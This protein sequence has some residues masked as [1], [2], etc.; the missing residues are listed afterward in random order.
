MWLVPAP[1]R[2]LLLSS[3]ASRSSWLAITW[4]GGHVGGQYNRTFPR[5]IYM[6]IEFSSQK[7]KMHTTTHTT[8]SMRQGLIAGFAKMKDGV[9]EF[10]PNTSQTNCFEGFWRITSK[11]KA[12]IEVR[13][14]KKSLCAIRQVDY[15]CHTSS[16]NAMNS[17]SLSLLPLKHCLFWY[18]LSAGTCLLVLTRYFDEKLRNKA[19]FGSKQL[20][21]LYLRHG[22]FSTKTANTMTNETKKNKS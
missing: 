21:W 9:D 6:K 18:L 3:F 10:R 7:R 2:L 14:E 13:K 12:K 8:M 17:F 15:V 20:Y 11:M 22:D 4:Q 1:S 16:A 5:S 19:S